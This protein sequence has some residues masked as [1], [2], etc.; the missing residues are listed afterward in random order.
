MGIRKHSW[1]ETHCSHRTK[2]KF[3]HSLKPT[4]S[5][6][7]W[8]NMLACSN[9]TSTHP[10]LCQPQARMPTMLSA[11]SDNQLLGRTPKRIWINNKHDNNKLNESETIKA[12][13]SF[14]FNFPSK[15]KACSAKEATKYVPHFKQQ[16]KTK[17][18]MFMPIKNQTN[19][20]RKAIPSTATHQPLNSPRTTQV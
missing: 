10:L 14:Y 11:S 1:I 9:L 19:Q 6:E 3:C 2:I 8:K 17:V 18:V 4:A 15:N 16:N 5:A 13:Q 12:N 7:Y 20:T